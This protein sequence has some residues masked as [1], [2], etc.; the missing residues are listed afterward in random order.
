M[1]KI[2]E[3]ILNMPTPAFGI[4]EYLAIQLVEIEITIYLTQ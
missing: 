1:G 4:Q 3:N 2:K